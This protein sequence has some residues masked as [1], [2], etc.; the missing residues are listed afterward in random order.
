[1]RPN[2]WNLLC[3]DEKRNLWADILM[4]VAEREFKKLLTALNESKMHNSLSGPSSV[5]PRRLKVEPTCPCSSVEVCGPAGWARS[6]GGCTGRFSGI[7]LLVRTPDHLEIFKFCKKMQCI[8]PLGRCWDN[9]AFWTYCPVCPYLS[10]FVVNK[11]FHTI[12]LTM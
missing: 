8:L 5:T 12:S 4:R 9:K 3:L 1:M 11:E 7:F 10:S 2:F 6:T